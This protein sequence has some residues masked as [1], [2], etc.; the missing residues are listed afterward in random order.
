MGFKL[1]PYNEVCT[2][3]TKSRY[4]VHQ[5]AKFSERSG[6]QCLDEAQRCR[7]LPDPEDEELDAKEM[8]DKTEQ[9]EGKRIPVVCKNSLAGKFRRECAVLAGEVRT[10]HHAL[11]KLRLR[12][13]KSYI[14]WC[15]NGGR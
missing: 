14:T 1:R 13:H 2:G 9:K 5:L 6:Q 8:E 3:R 7:S 4:R 10:I 15:G 11:E 12:S